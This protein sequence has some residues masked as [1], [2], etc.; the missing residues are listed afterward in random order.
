MKL[1]IWLIIGIIFI[2]ILFQLLLRFHN[3][4]LLKSVTSINRGTKSERNLILKLLKNGI[5]ELTIF[6]D[7]YIKTN[8]GKTS[9]IDLVLATTEGVI[10]IEVKDYKGWIYGNGN[11]SHWTQSLAFGNIKHRFYN[12]IKQNKSHIKSLKS[13]LKQFEK[14]PFYSL[15]VFYGECELKE[16]NYIPKG[17][18]IVKQH[19]LLEVLK[20]IKE[21]N[22]P[23]TYTNKREIIRVLKNAV[24]NGE[25]KIN[26]KKHI[27]NIND[28]IGK[29]RIYD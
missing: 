1:I 19:R 15:I 21:N 17:T 23:A 25:N 26:Q 28:M 8:Q 6:H 20:N 14:I 22:E 12:P 2:I 11:Y 5:H 29:D 3:I 10:V 24:K 7:L 9:Q 4:K 18:F 16:I 27:D 13:E